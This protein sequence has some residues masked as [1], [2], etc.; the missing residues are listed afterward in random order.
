MIVSSCASAVR[1]FSWASS[2][3]AN[4]RAA[5]LRKLFVGMTVPLK[6]QVASRRYREGCRCRA[7]RPFP[8]S[9]APCAT[10]WCDIFG[11]RCARLIGA[12]TCQFDQLYMFHGR[13]LGYPKPDRSMSMAAVFINPQ[14]NCQRRVPDN[15]ITNPLTNYFSTA[16]LLLAIE[17]SPHL[18][19][20]RGAKRNEFFPRP[21]L[22]KCIV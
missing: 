18:V 9:P 22:K 6:C 17:P 15:K 21:L 5:W 13:S 12:Q 4:K 14:R 1:A 10:A 3:R 19:E 7:E 2:A 16:R 11:G 20:Q 8:D